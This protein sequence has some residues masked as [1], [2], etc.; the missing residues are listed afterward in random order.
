M[1]CPKVFGITYSRYRP[2]QNIRVPPN[3]MQ[4]SPSLT[5]KLFQYKLYVLKSKP[6]PYVSN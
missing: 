5:L 3:V 1:R 4:I 6:G 2:K